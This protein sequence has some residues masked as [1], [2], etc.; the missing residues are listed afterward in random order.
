MA[1]FGETARFRSV[2]RGAVFYLPSGYKEVR[3]INK[4]CRNYKKYLF[5]VECPVCKRKYSYKEVSGEILKTRP[6]FI[7]HT[8][9]LNDK[10]ERILGFPLTHNN[11]EADQLFSVQVPAGVLYD[12]A[13]EDFQKIPSYILVNQTKTYSIELISFQNLAVFKL[14]QSIVSEVEKIFSRF[15]QFNIQDINL[16]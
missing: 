13:Q 14:E 1:S 4:S 15:L 8:T 5:D 9:T 3:C 7:W 11:K 2:I 10:T 16:Q 12:Y 6:V